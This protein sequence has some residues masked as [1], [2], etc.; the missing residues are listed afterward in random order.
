M[1]IFKEGDALAAVYKCSIIKIVRTNLAIL[2]AIL[3]FT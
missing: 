3:R 2:K 1:R